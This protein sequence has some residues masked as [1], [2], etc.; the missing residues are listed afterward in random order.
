MTPEEAWFCEASRS[1]RALMAMSD[2]KN[3][4][5]VEECTKAFDQVENES[6]SNNNAVVLRGGL[7][8]MTSNSRL[9]KSGRLWK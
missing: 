2:Y 5:E 7:F 8:A 3:M 1:V 6:Q 9:S 4:E